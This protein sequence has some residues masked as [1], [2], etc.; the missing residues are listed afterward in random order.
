MGIKMCV[1]EADVFLIVRVEEMLLYSTF[2]NRKLLNRQVVW[3]SL[4]SSLSINKN[5]HRHSHPN[6]F[7]YSHTYTAQH[8]HR[9]VG[10]HQSGPVVMS[11]HLFHFHSSVSSFSCLLL[12]CPAL[13]LSSLSFSAL[14]FFIT[15]PLL[16]FSVFHSNSLLLFLS[17]SLSYQPFFARAVSLPQA[18]CVYISVVYFYKCQT[19][20]LPSVYW[21]TESQEDE[22]SEAQGKGGKQITMKKVGI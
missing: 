21:S 3:T 18:S 20:F 22:G 15:S 12:P 4:T 19:V 6:S 10:R 1:L 7:T 9:G 17:L 8:T 14:L 13:I 5:S 11:F 2:F 16:S